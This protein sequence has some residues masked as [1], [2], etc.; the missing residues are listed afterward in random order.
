MLKAT[1]YMEG[2]HTT[3]DLKY[4][5]NTY[6]GHIMMINVTRFQ[7]L[8][9]VTLIAGKEV[10]YLPYIEYRPQPSHGIE[11]KQGSIC[12]PE[13]KILYQST[14][15]RCKTRPVKFIKVDDK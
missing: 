8:S 14:M 11:S 9:H 2:C 1:S 3:F 5:R 7:C 6:E 4:P 10:E 12:L 15:V 13:K